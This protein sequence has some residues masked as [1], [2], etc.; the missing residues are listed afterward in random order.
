MREKLIELID[1]KQVYGIDQEQPRKHDIMLLD[2]DELA[3]HLIANGVTFATDTNVG[4]KWIPVTERLP[5]D[6]DEVLIYCGSYHEIGWYDPVDKSWR[7]D[8]LGSCTEDVT[9]WMPM[10]EPPKEG[11]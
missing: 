10:P 11:E 6:F 2:N 7:S 3:D 8:F 9:H 1:E 4:S 5:G